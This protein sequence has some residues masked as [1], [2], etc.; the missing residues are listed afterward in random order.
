MIRF[1]PSTQ[2]GFIGVSTTFGREVGQFG[3]IHLVEE[4]ESEP[5]AGH[6]DTN[7]HT[8]KTKIQNK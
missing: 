2:A 6:E 8:G 7:Q 3:I 5:L 4:S 1:I